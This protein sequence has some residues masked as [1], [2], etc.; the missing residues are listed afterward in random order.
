MQLSCSMPANKVL[1]LIDTASDQSIGQE[2]YK[3]LFIYC[4]MVIRLG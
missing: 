3:R 4:F 1:S 2:I